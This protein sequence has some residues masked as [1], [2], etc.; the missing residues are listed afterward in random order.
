MK[1]RPSR[2]T[3][4]APAAT[5]PPAR[6]PAPKA[7]VSQ[8]TPDPPR[9]RTWTASTAIS[10]T[11]APRSNVWANA[12]IATPPGGAI[13]QNAPRPLVTS[14]ATWAAPRPG[15]S[16]V[17]G[18]V[19]RSSDSVAAA[20]APAAAAMAA[21]GAA[22]ASRPPASSGPT[23]APELSITAVTALDAASSAG[24]RTSQGNTAAWS[25]R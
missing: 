16:G 9:A 25:G 8:P 17:S 23:R 12:K 4:T 21:A 22:T 1:L 13:R 6:P 3:R 19:S 20:R 15:S 7:A 14:R 24:V 10:T 2:V 5:A 11:S 18:T